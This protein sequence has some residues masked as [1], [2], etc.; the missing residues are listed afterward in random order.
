M[1]YELT[2]T[3][4]GSVYV[5]Y[6]PAEA[7]REDSHDAYL[8]VANYSIVDGF[9]HLV[10]HG[11]VDGFTVAPLRNGAEIVTEDADSTRAYFA[12]PDVPLQVEVFDP[13]EGKALELVSN[14]SIVLLQNGAS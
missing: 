3:T 14:G 2:Y 1:Q 6:L 12:F 8:T 7:E 4:S 11:N 9:N 5:R 13:E 10:E